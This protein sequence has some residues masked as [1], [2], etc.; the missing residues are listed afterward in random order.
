MEGREMTADPQPH[1][2]T[3]VWEE[4]LLSQ[5]SAPAEKC[6]CESTQYAEYLGRIME[7]LSQT[8]QRSLEILP[9]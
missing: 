6:P 3:K 4:M 1:F 2:P 9:A 5:P 7:D 8:L